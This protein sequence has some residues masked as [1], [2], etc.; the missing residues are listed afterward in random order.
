LVCWRNRGWSRVSAPRIL[1]NGTA[2]ELKDVP[3]MMTLLDWLRG[4]AGLK[5]TKEGCAEGDCGACTVVVER[6]GPH[7]SIDRLAINACLTMVG[8][9][10][11][12]GVRT[13]E[14]L[15]SADGA[16]HPVQVAFVA[17]GGTQCGF[18][19]PGFV[20]AAYAFVA[21]GEPPELAR[22][23]EALAG[24]LCRCTGYRSIVEAVA[25]VAPLAQEGAD[26][27][28]ATLASLITS[29]PQACFKTPAQRF[30]VPSNLAEAAALRARFPQAM[31]LAGGTDLG[32]LVSRERQI[33][34]HVIHLA[35]VAELG[36]IVDG[37]DAL[38]I[39]AAVTYAAA[40]EV[41]VRHY[42]ALKPYLARLG[43]RQIRNIGTIGGNL[44]TASPIGD[45]LPVLL[46]L[47]ARIRLV[48][49]ARG[50]REAR[51]VEFFVGYRRP[52]V[53]PDELIAAV[54]LPKLAADAVFFVDKISKRYDQDISTV[55]AAYRLSI[56]G[57]T[58]REVRLAFGG[59]AETPR[60]ALQAE[61]ALD[62][63]TLDDTAFASA[64]AALREEF[65]PISD[66]RGSAQYRMMVA[67]N[68]LRRLQLRLTAPTAAIE[69]DQL[70]A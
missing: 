12:L 23:H 49:A 47:D 48:S 13:V 57:G 68:L 30:D 33:I 63:R 70:W 38:T 54:I 32:L 6:P 3:P 39:G 20:M 22:I 26:Q 29:A 51:A 7:G 46:A 24:N 37:P 56:A 14:G 10:D 1:L 44:G 53:A 35:N 4:P 64:I 58:M 8:Q 25:R 66:W 41:L 21:G 15:T 67:T 34:P 69:V 18:C 40:Q 28:A 2:T 65:R 17:T 11:G 19:T 16:L 59:M 5:G 43:S 61:Q 55:C 52:A 45:F 36:V 27:S 42:P 62:G 50:S 60:R 9:V 31:L